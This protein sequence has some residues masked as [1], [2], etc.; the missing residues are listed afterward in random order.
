MPKQVCLGTSLR[1]RLRSK[2]FITHLNNL[3]HSICYD[4]VLQADATWA[5]N[6]LEKGD[7]FAK[8]PKNLSKFFL[9]Q[10]ASD[11]GNYEQENTSQHITNKGVIPVW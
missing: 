2:E 4:E 9:M 5:S 11:M 7:G 1:S 10:A 6:I 3:G 8:L